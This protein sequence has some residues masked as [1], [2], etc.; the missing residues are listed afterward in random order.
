MEFVFFI[1]SFLVYLLVA[2]PVCL[3]LHELGHAAMILALTRQSATFRFGG[4][5]R[6][7]ELRLGRITAVI[8]RDLHALFFCGYRLQDRKALTWNQDLW[9]TL[10]GP[11]SSLIFTLLFASIWWRTGTSDPWSGMT[12]I[13]LFNFIIA[14]VPGYYP[15]LFAA[16]GGIANDGLQIVRLA[17]SRAG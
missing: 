14:G 6:A 4:Q 12:W 1:L 8:H 9:I 3:V 2:A 11:L 16:E 7:H 17:R 10:G 5:G 15:R 13:N